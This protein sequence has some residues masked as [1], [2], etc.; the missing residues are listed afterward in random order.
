MTPDAGATNGGTLCLGVRRRVA[1]SYGRAGGKG[2]SRL[3]EGG[4]SAIGTLCRVAKIAKACP[5][6]TSPTASSAVR[7]QP[8]R[9]VT[10]QRWGCAPLQKQRGH[11]A[12]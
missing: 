9:S 2:P 1:R 7:Q 12:R 11:G 6:A 8:K 4:R 10:V 3:T 5:L